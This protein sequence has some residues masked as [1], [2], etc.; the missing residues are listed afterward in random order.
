MSKK[1]RVLYFINFAPNYRDV[2]LREFGKYV[3]LTV[4]SYDGTEVN[5]KNPEERV[6]AACEG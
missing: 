3:D 1:Y 4:V 5:M 2:F 6:G